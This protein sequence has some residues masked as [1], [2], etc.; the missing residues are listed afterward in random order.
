MFVLPW[1]W[2]HSVKG[3][4]KC[5]HPWKIHFIF[6]TVHKPAWNKEEWRGNSA[7]QLIPRFPLRG[8][9]CSWKILN[10]DGPILCPFRKSRASGPLDPFMYLGIQNH[11]L[12]PKLPDNHNS[13]MQEYVVRQQTRL[14][15]LFYTSFKNCSCSSPKR[16]FWKKN[17]TS[18]F[19][20]TCWVGVRRL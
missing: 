2:E 19:K 5:W 6:G 4:A 18:I 12:Y 13:Y 11:V 3:G 8:L 7:K 10:V 1:Y 20:T 17:T 9:L 15:Q 14:R 16:L